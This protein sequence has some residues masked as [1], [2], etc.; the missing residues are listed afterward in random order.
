[1]AGE[2]S[3]NSTTGLD[4]FEI[5]EGISPGGNEEL[6]D[7]LID[8]ADENSP[9]GP[10]LAPPHTVTTDAVSLEIDEDE[11]SLSSYA[12]SSYESGSPE[13]TET[14]SETGSSSYESYTGSSSASDSADESALSADED[15]NFGSDDIPASAYAGAAG[16]VTAGATVANPVGHSAELDYTGPELAHSA[17]LDYAGGDDLPELLPRE[18]AQAPA[19]R[20]FARPGDLPSGGVV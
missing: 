3:P 17:E 2:T 1:M 7:S 15:S 14:G 16:A 18:A 13:E 12:S 20:G 5:G 11:E 4:Q 10:G 8:I 19:P 6:L 9:R